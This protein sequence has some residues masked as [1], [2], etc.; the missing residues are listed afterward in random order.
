MLKL[1]QIVSKMTLEGLGVPEEKITSH[2]GSLTHTLRL[3]HYG[4]QSD[5]GSGLSMGAH[6]DFNM[7]TL[8]VQH[9]VEGLEVQAKDGSWILI[10][11]EPDTF[12][13]QAGDLLTVRGRESMHSPNHI[14]FC[15][16]LL[17]QCACGV[18]YV[19]QVVTNGRVPASVHR[20][21]T[22]SNRERFSLVFGS[23]SR[24]GDEVRAMDELVDGEN[25]LLYNPCRPDEYIEFV[26]T[27]EGY[28]KL[29]DPLKAFCGV[30]DGTCTSME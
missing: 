11:P 4:V 17:Q 14:Q 20:V 29:D 12:T 27:K 6:R 24:D 3:C 22:A 21:R 19:L 2:L 26:L 10:R 9:E 7:S 25:P 30:H 18:I 8:V 1:Q 15:L 28:S 13:F 23:W 16:L 5:T